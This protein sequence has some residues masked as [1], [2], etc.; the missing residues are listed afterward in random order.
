MSAHTVFALSTFARTH[1]NTMSSFDTDSSFW[2]W[3]NLA[4]GPVCNNEALFLSKL[5]PS[6]NIV[7]AATGLIEPTLMGTVHLRITDDNGDK[8]K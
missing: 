2:V 3:D 5:V 6:I 4:T 7:K 1:Q 8:H